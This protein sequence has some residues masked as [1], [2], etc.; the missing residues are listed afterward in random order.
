MCQHNTAFSFRP[1]FTQRAPWYQVQVR[2]AKHPQTI[3]LLCISHLHAA[4]HCAAAGMRGK[5]LKKVDAAFPRARFKSDKIF[6]LGY[7]FLFVKVVMQPQTPTLNITL[8]QG[9]H[10]CEQL[11]AQSEKYNA[12]ANRVH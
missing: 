5:T 11:A 8:R 6:R 1:H 7:T 4:R 12:A 9:Q 2:P 10:S 3:S